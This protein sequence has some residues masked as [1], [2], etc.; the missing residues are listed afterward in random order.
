VQNHFQHSGSCLVVHRRKPLHFASRQKIKALLQ[1]LIKH[2]ATKIQETLE[3]QLHSFSISELDGGEWSASRFGQAQEK[4]AHGAHCIGD[5]VGSIPGLNAVDEKYV[6]L[7]PG[8]DLRPPIPWMHG[9]HKH[10]FKTECCVAFS[11]Y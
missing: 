2:R 4:G 7:L 3:V 6:L 11:G 8:I 9:T 1:R 5:W 10:N